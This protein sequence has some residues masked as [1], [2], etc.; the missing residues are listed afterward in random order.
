MYHRVRGLVLRGVPYKENALVLTLLTAELGRVTV[1]AYGARGRSGRLAAGTQTLCWS[2]F[3]LEERRGRLTCGEASVLE[4]FEGLRKELS[5]LA[6]GAYFARLL[7]L[8]CAENVPDEP[9]L[10]L[11]LNALYAVGGALWPQEH[12]KAAFELRLL[13]GAGFRPR[14]ESCAVCGAAEPAEPMFSPLAGLVHCRGCGAG[15]QG[16][17]LPLDAESLAAMRYVTDAPPKRVFSRPPVGEDSARRFH[18]AAESFARAQLELPGAALDYW[19][20][21]R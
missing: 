2:E 4:S 15:V 5:A 13:A 14:L 6:L 1:S 20:K 11:G 16:A 8:V 17:S 10:R 3:V 12:I 18:R 9:S 7:E 19:K 21:V